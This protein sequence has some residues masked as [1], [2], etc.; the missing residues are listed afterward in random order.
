MSRHAGKLRLD[1]LPRSESIKLTISLNAD[2][3]QLLAIT[4]LHT[5]RC[6]AKAWIQRRLFRTYCGRSSLAIADSK[7]MASKRMVS[8]TTPAAP[9]AP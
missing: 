3:K 1:P 5:R 6:T 2:L 7:A 4:R 9:P 8:G